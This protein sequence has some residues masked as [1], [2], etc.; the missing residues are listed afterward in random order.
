MTYGEGAKLAYEDYMQGNHPT[1]DELPSE[2]Q[3][4][5][6][7]VYMIAFGEGSRNK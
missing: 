5:F 3:Q 2:R 4:A 7:H 6:I 1:W